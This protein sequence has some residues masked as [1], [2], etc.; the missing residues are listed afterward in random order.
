MYDSLKLI[1]QLEESLSNSEELEDIDTGLIPEM[2]ENI[3][4]LFAMCLA[5]KAS[6]T[7]DQLQIYNAEY[8]RYISALHLTSVKP[9]Q[10][11]E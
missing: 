3:L 5:L 11:D 10:D 8:E 7:E 9:D 2:N 1:K 6:L 4:R